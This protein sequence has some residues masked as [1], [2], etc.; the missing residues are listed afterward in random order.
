M[1]K[2]LILGALDVLCWCGGLALFIMVVFAV[3][4]PLHAQGISPFGAGEKGGGTNR[5]VTSK[6]VTELA[7]R[8]DVVTVDQLGQIHGDGGK[9]AQTAETE[10]VNEVAEHCAEI[11]DSA[12]SSMVASMNMV[13]AKTNNMATAGIG[14]ALAFRPETDDPNVRGYVVLS[15]Y[16]P[17][18]Q[19]DIQWVHYNVELSLPPNRTV[20]YET[21]NNSTKVKCVWDKWDAAGTNMVV[22]G[23]AWQGLHRCT[24]ARPAWCLGKSCLDLP[25]EEWGG[26]GGMDWG[27]M[28][29]THD[30]GVAYFTGYVTNGI[31]HEV[32]YF[33]NGFFKE[34]KTE[35]E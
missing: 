33:D 1:S 12:N 10:A 24:V 6:T 7:W 35:N 28:V 16:D 14:I 26:E 22:S 11:S 21:Y 27:D 31:T 15:E 13:Y 30:N 8:R 2:R 29:L 18:T 17:L 19:K 20:T 4:L 25:N 3:S 34:I 32:A 23:L 5:V 9:V